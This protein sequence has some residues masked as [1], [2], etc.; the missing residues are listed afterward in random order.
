MRDKPGL[1][2]D[3]AESGAT[4]PIRPI[5]LETLCKGQTFQEIS[6]N[7][8][9]TLSSPSSTW[10]PDLLSINKPLICVYTTRY[11][12]REGLEVE[13]PICKH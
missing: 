13:G 5:G 8:I 10:G 3:M 11:F 12:D 4:L 6:I 2:L 7:A 1:A 9:D